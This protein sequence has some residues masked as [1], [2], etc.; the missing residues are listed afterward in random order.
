MLRFLLAFYISVLSF[1]F[2]TLCLSTVLMTLPLPGTDTITL[3]S[4]TPLRTSKEIT[5]DI[6]L[7]DGQL[8]VYRHSLDLT[9]YLRGDSAENELMLY[10]ALVAF[11]DA[12]HMLLWNQSEPAILE[13]SD[14]MRICL[15]QTIDDGIILETDPAAIA[16]RASRPKADTREIFINEQTIMPAYLTAEE[17]MQQRTGQL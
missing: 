10:S 15:D 1:A 4:C 13:N 5:G 12:A 16:S 11:S 2:L 9:F 7:Y 8:A 6:I 17:K 3:T 14:L